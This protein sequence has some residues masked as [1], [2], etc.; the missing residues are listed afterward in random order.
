MHI[1]S[2]FDHPDFLNT[3][4]SIKRKAY[5][6]NVPCGVHVVEPSDIYLNEKIAEGYRF[7]AYSID[8][9]FLINSSNNPIL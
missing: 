5:H 6:A 9:M 2:Q 7:I 1:S 3:M 4:K 8:S